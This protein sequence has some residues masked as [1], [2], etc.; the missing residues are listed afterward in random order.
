MGRNF[1]G[2][3]IK[4]YINGVGEEYKVVGNFYLGSGLGMAND[5]L[6]GLCAQGRPV[7]QPAV[8]PGTN[9]ISANGEYTT[10]PS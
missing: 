1:F 6:R 5:E 9:H 7:Q 10:L 4:I 3:K 2:K 8:P